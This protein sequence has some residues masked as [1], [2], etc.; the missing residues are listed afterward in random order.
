MKEEYKQVG[1][2]YAV[3]EVGRGREGRGGGNQGHGDGGRYRRKPSTKC[4]YSGLE[5]KLDYL[6]LK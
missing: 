5:I 2:R 4:V 1:Q 6:F 3:G